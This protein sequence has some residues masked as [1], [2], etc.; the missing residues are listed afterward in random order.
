ML[1]SIIIP[2]FNSEK[3]IEDNISSIKKQSYSEYEIIVI[4]NNSNDRT[5]EIINQNNFKNIKIISE[6]DK[7]IF[8]A[9][10][11]GI[12]NSSG[13]IISILHS[14]D[15]FA[16]HKVLEKITDCFDEK[17][18]DM[19]YGD[20]VYVRKENINK[21]LRYWKPGLFKD[22]MF[23]KGW[24]PPHPSFFVKKKLFYSFGLYK[25]ENGNS[26]DIELMYRYLQVNKISFHYINETLVKMRYGGASN[27]NINN[28]IKKNIQILKFL[29]I[30]KSLYKIFVFFIFKF[31]NRLNQ[32]LIKK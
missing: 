6:R 19:I 2:T 29:G 4:D 23:L 7:G 25:I 27:K 5:L 21:I 28:I 31:F 8:D 24:S 22:N 11:K 1:I 20:L 18:V 14:D 10:N 26:A 30:N 15:F 17:K 16:N 3:T 32:F 9:I 12:I 13:E